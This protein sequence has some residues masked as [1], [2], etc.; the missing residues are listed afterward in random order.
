MRKEAQR[1]SNRADPARV[2][3]NQLPLQTTLH[4]EAP[5]SY[6]AMPYLEAIAL[7]EGVDS[8][9]DYEHDQRNKPVLL[10]QPL[11][12]NGH[13]PLPYLDIRQAIMQLQLDRSGR[14]IP[15]SEN[16]K[17]HLDPEAALVDLDTTS[18]ADAFVAPRTWADIEVGS[19]L[20]SIQNRRS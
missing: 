14:T 6:L 13:E 12:P 1:P 9:I 3:R 16:N 10:D 7:C 4:F 15:S 2:P 5:P 11:S 18:F 20:S 19:S 8:F 17:A